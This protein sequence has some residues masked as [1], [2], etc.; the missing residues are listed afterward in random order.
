MLKLDDV[1]NAIGKMNLDKSLDVRSLYL[2]HLKYAH[3][4]VLLS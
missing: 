3:P 1:G 2:E 4:I